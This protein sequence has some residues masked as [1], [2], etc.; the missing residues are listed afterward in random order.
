[1]IYNYEFEALVRRGFCNYL[2]DE[3]SSQMAAQLFG[4]A[5]SIAEKSSPI[6]K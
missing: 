6:A 4:A 5:S 3:L 1:L 2:L